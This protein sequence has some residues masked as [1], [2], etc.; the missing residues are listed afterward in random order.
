M[1]APNL[2]LLGGALLTSAHYTSGQPGR[3][4]QRDY[5]TFNVC[6][7]VPGEAIAR[8]LGGKLVQ[9]RPF[10]DKSF[11]RCTYFVLPPG[12]SQQLG[13]VVY[14][15]P[16]DDFEEL[17]KYIEAPITAV[18]GLG[19]GAYMFHDPGDDR[20]KINV[21]KRGDLMFEATGESAATARKVADAVAALLWKKA[22]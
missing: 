21:L 22:P 12:S 5:V 15:Q 20:F 9:V 10:G 18:A 2:I 14:V 3:P 8:A 17:K 4:P 16:P 11:S 1:T 7:V 19:D 13:Y 6:Q